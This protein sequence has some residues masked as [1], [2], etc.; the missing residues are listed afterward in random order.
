MTAGEILVE[1][2]AAEIGQK[3]DRPGKF[4]GPFPSGAPAIFIDQVARMGADCGLIARIG[5][6]DFGE[7]NKKRLEADGVDG[8]K[9]IYTPDYTT[10]TAFVT[11]FEDRSRKF[12]YPFT[13]AAAGQLGPAPARPG[14]SDIGHRHVPHTVFPRLR[15]RPPV[16]APHGQARDAQRSRK[17]R[18]HPQ[19]VLPD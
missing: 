8:S 1:I 3:F 11:Y 7:L 16:I 9:I 2:M 18:D 17:P 12:I 19:D 14:A 13:H 10:G 6:D 15:Q 4:I 5:E